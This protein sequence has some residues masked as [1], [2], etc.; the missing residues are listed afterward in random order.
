MKLKIYLAVLVGILISLVY[1]S[2]LGLTPAKREISFSTEEQEFTYTIINNE[3]KDLDLDLYATGEI[4]DF[5]EFETSKLHISANELTKDFK[6][7]VKPPAYLKPGKNIG[8]IVVEEYVP[9]INIGNTTVYAKIRV[10]SKLIINVPYPKKYVEVSID[11]NKTPSGELNLIA[12]VK[13][14]GQEN[15]EKVK[16]YFGIYEQ[17]KKLEDLE[18][19]EESLPKGDIK[20]LIV[21]LNT[22]NLQNGLYTAKAT[23][24]YDQY[25]VELGRD[26]KVGDV[27]IE[28]L[29]YTKYFAQGM[30]NRFD[31]DVENKWNRKIRNAYGTVDIENVA[32]LKTLTY[33]LDPRERRTITTYWDTSNVM[34]GKYNANITL[35]YVNKTTSKQAELN[36]ISKEEY[37]RMF[38][39][40]PV[41]LIVTIGI[42]VVITNIILFLLIYKKKQKSPL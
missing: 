13:N 29:D 20:D 12:K 40:V 10:I 15:I 42:G 1:A 8:K 2:A 39:K 4:A 17:D 18:S 16:A 26:F 37:E 7:K 41:W 14:L 5:I 9:E 27:Y 6:I 11:V 33:D 32:F 31:I 38:S 24:V 34:I 35:F 30:V 28:I 21:T 23:I 3:Q 25:E 36:V 22:S 19:N